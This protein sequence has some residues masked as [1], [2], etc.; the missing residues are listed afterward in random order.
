MAPTPLPVHQKGESTVH[1]G[2][3]KAL[4]RIAEGTIGGEQNKDTSIQKFSKICRDLHRN[5]LKTGAISWIRKIGRNPQTRLR[6]IIKGRGDPEGLDD[7]KRRE[8]L[9]A[10]LL[11]SV[12]E[13]SDVSGD[14]SHVLAESET[15]SNETEI[16]VSRA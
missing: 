3:P 7:R 14:R 1:P 9:P 6:F 16:T 8:V 4:S 5:R 2:A 11:P 10:L 12:L 15:L 13:N